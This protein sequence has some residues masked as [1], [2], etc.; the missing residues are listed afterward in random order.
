MMTTTM[1][2]FAVVA[3]VIKTL[4]RKDGKRTTTLS[5]RKKERSHTRENE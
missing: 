3:R 2:S 1:A 4:G 5:K